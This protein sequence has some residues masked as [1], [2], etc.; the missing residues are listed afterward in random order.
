MSYLDELIA[1]LNKLPPEV[2][3]LLRL[4]SSM[5]QDKNYNILTKSSWVI[6][7]LGVSKVVSHPLFIE[8]LYFSILM[9]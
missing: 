2:L 6:K 4:K 8:Y 9:G 5:K 7:N 1:K 3:K